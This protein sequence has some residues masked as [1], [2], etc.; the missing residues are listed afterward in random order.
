MWDSAT[1]LLGFD[2]YCQSITDLDGWCL[3]YCAKQKIK[4]LWSCYITA[5][6]LNDGWCVVGV[7]GAFMTGGFA[8]EHSACQ[9]MHVSFSSSVL[10]WGNLTGRDTSINLISLNCTVSLHWEAS[11]LTSFTKTSLPSNQRPLVFV[12]YS[13]KMTSKTTWK[14]K[15]QWSFSKYIKPKYDIS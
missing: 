8:D 10:R 2:N 1:L 4:Q 6:R 3:L 13:D 14:I 15:G 9:D 12:L 7:N 5:L 11:I